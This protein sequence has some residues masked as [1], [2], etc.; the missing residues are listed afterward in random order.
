MS[1]NNLKLT[2]VRIDPATLEKLDKFVSRHDYWTRNAVINQILTAVVNRFDEKAIYD[3]VRT[4]RFL[5]EPV[6][7][8]YKINEVPKP[9]E[10]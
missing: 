1:N 8:I 9:N 7:A 6:T 3:M 5:R 10:P 4:W 2:S